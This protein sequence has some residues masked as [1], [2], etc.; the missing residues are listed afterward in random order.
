[1]AALCFIV[2]KNSFCSW[3]SGVLEHYG[4]VISKTAKRA[5]KNMNS[6]IGIQESD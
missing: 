6:A 2:E 5:K 1:M 3:S 4:E